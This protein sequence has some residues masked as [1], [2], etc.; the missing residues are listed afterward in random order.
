[1]YFLNQNPFVRILFPFIAGIIIS[2]YVHNH[3]VFALF[4]LIIFAISGFLIFTAKKSESYRFRWIQGVL[5]GLFFLSFGLF[6]AD[7][8]S[9]PSDRNLHMHQTDKPL[10]LIVRIDDDVE[11]KTNSVKSIVKCEN[12]IGDSSITI[13]SEKI[14][15]YFYRDTLSEKLRYGDRLLINSYL[16]IPDEAM[17]PY[18]FNYRKYL[19]QQG[20][21][22][23]S[24][25]GHDKWK[26]LER[27]KGSKL[28]SFALQLRTSILDILRSQLGD[29]DEY[30]VAAAI[31]AGY[32]TALDSDLRQTFANA[33][34]M[35]VMCVSGLHVGIIFIILSSLLK[36]LSD[37]KL[38]QRILKVI[39]ILAFIWFYALLT[40]F[41]ASVL[42]ASTM[43]SFVAAGMMVQR[44]IPI[45]NSLAAS[46]FLLLLFNPVY[47][48]Q[49]GFQL[50]YLA[51]IGIVALFP[52]IQKLIPA[53][54]K[55][56]IKIR[57]LIA[58]SIA[59][60]IATTPISLYYFNQFPNYFILTNI[61]VVPLA[62][63]IIYT[64][65]PALLFNNLQFAGD[66]FAWLLGVLMKIMNF[67]VR[68]IDSL[69]G[70]VSHHV[71]ISFS[72]MFL[73][74]A[75]I[76]FA[77]H[78]IMSKKKILM[79]TSAA[80]LLAF[81]F[82]SSLHSIRQL[83]HHEIVYP[84]GAGNVIVF[85]ENGKCE[86]LTG[87]TSQTFRKQFLWSMG[88]YLTIHKIRETVFVPRD[89]IIHSN[90]HL[91]HF[92]VVQFM[93]KRLLLWD[94]TWSAEQKKDN[95]QTDYVLLENNPFVRFDEMKEM[96]EGSVF[97]FTSANKRN[98][99]NIWERLIKEYD[100]E[101]VNMYKSGAL[102]IK[103]N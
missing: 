5:F 93:D 67:S 89:S 65:I 13:S 23:T 78:G 63:F 45:Y 36:F 84:Y 64:A 30:M 56:F 77:F 4:C 76:L 79:S 101:Y 8:L 27:D 87:D 83:H 59:A 38:F 74:Y 98:I 16:Q 2:P 41:S 29:N 19:L 81:A 61:I 35:H 42:R 22:Y 96:F 6:Y 52:H 62:G 69:P 48:F 92:P 17:N 37:K 15:V 9:H 95:I 55:I 71:F 102:V 46:A 88:K 66:V 40:G 33:G 97:V 103:K 14:L 99:V 24:W 44:K 75:V 20:I 51:V 7:T 43:F 3:L 68:F 73:L 60:Q 85:A 80:A 100:L 94:D 1:M 91:Y 82:I 57:D 21:T 70:A 11:I 72:Q 31:V 10:T 90:S 86:V 39:L 25:V 58:V 50:S 47:I 28:K 18:A 26:I 54:E 32:R 49:V 34:A 53:K 12:H